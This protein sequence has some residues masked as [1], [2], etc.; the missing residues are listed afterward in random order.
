MAYHSG[1]F[2]NAEQKLS[3][4]HRELLAIVKSVRHFSYDLIGQKFTIYTDHQ[5]LIHL[6]TAKNRGELNTKLFNAMVYLLNFDFNV[7]HKRGNDPIMVVSDA[8][9]RLPF[10][11]E[12]LI[13][14]SEVSDIPEKL[15]LIS[16]LPIMNKYQE[17]C[18]HYFLR[19][20][21]KELKSHLKSNDVDK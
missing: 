8:I 19:S 12:D 10:T 16:S 3:S 14:Y 4:R 11:K 20:T 6:M 9:S 15:F 17:K 1:V 21:M 7:I 18:Q 13:K 5:S 2:S